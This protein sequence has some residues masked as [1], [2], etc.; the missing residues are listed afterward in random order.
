MTFSFAAHAATYIAAPRMQ[1]FCST[2][3]GNL[4]RITLTSQK[5]LPCCVF[6]TSWVLI[7]AS[8]KTYSLAFEECT[9]VFHIFQNHSSASYTGFVLTMW[10]VCLRYRHFWPTQTAS[11]DVLHDLLNQT[12]TDPQLRPAPRPTR[13][14]SKPPLQLQGNWSPIVTASLLLPCSVI[15]TLPC[16]CCVITLYSLIGSL[17]SWILPY[18][19]SNSCQNHGDFQKFNWLPRWLLIAFPFYECLL[20]PAATSLLPPSTWNTLD[21]PFFSLLPLS[22]SE[23]QGRSEEAWELQ[24]WTEDGG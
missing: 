9:S 10:L 21:I 13:L 12:V 6:S 11:I 14:T 2:L 16:F 5:A 15:V 8:S 23:V 19:S 18:Y 24:A 3:H 1:L 22:G 20:K 4:G 7:S 17:W